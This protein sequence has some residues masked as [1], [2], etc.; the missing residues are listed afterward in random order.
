MLPFHAGVLTAW[1]KTRSWTLSGHFHETW[2]NDLI[3]INEALAGWPV[4]VDYL[5]FEDV[6]KQVSEY[7]VIINAGF[8]GSAWS[9]GE[10]WNDSRAVERLRNMLQK[11]GCIL[12]VFQPSMTTGYM[13]NFRL[14]DVLGVDQDMGER[15]APWAYRL[16]EVRKFLW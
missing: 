7:D 16:S 1:G 10:Q 9:G 8:A 13:A 5:D 3:H 14:A 6:K 12:G 15:V 2:K 11:G 4:K